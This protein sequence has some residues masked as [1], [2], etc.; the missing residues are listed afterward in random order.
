MTMIVTEEQAKQINSIDFGKTIDVEL[1]IGTTDN[2][3][4]KKYKYFVEF[5]KYD[6][7][8]DKFYFNIVT[9]KNDS[10]G[11][12]IYEINNDVIVYRLVFQINTTGIS[13]FNTLHIPM[14]ISNKALDVVQTKFINKLINPILKEEE[15]SE[16]LQKLEDERYEFFKKANDYIEDFEHSLE[17]NRRLLSGEPKA[18]SEFDYINDMSDVWGYFMSRGGV[19]LLDKFFQ[20]Y[21]DYVQDFYKSNKTGKPHEILDY[22]HNDYEPVQ[23]EKHKALSFTDDVEKMI[24]FMTLTKWEFLQSYSYLTEEEY[25]VTEGD[26]NQNWY[27]I[28]NNLFLVLVDRLKNISAACPQLAKDLAIIP[29]TLALKHEV[30]ANVREGV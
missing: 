17:D 12:G 5:V 11:K 7:E 29:L 2:L 20:S 6:R 28:M 15:M 30:V 14:A 8:L 23:R 10:L 26:M 3:K 22:F 19:D 18:K 27:K 24:D 21:S 9:L 16:D 25:D 13:L 4:L 1:N